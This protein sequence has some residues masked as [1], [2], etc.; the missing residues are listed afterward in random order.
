MIMK[1]LKKTGKIISVMLALLLI[2]QSGFGM[3]IFADDADDPEYA[4]ECELSPAVTDF[5]EITEDNAEPE[6]LLM[7]VDKGTKDREISSIADEAGAAVETVSRMEDG[8]KL[9]AVQI[10]PEAVQETADSLAE[11]ESVLIVQPNYRYSI[12][13]EEI[14]ETT[15]DESSVQGASIQAGETSDI[16]LDRQQYLSDPEG[17][18]YDDSEETDENLSGCINAFGAWSRLGAYSREDRVRVAV[19][20]TGALISHPDLAANINKD[21]CVTFNNGVKGSFKEWDGYEDDHGHGTHVCGIIAAETDNSK[22]VA[23][24]ACNR[25][26]VFCIDAACT[27]NN[28]VFT[29]QDICMS[30][31][32]AVEQGA[33]LINLSIG[34]L[35]RDLLMERSVR[36]AWDRGI[37]CIC[38]A[39]NEGSDAAQSP[40]DSPC[41]ISVKAHDVYGNGVSSSNYS[42][43][44]DV[45]APGKGIF[46]TCLKTTKDSRGRTVPYTPLTATY[47]NKSGTSMAA[48]V[49]TGIAALLLSEDGSLTPRQLKNYIYTSSGQGSYMGLHG[50]PGFGMV[51]AA[52]AVRDLHSSDSSVTDMILNRTYAEIYK[53][54][55]VF[56]E[57]AVLPAEAGRRA[58]DA[59]YSSSDES[60]ASVDS[61]GMITGTGKGTAVISVS[62]GGVSRECIVTVGSAAVKSFSKRPFAVTGYIEEDDPSVIVK[63]SSWDEWASGADIYQT[64]AKAKEKLSVSLTMY[65]SASI[66]YLQITKKD[67]TVLKGKVYA[68]SSSTKKVSFSY[69]V[70]AAGAYRIMVLNKPYNN[71][72]NQSLRYDLKVNSVIMDLS[73]VAVTKKSG[74][75]KSFTVKWKKLSR[76]K[77]KKI[78]KIQLQYSTSFGF[79]SGT[80][81]T[82]YAK[83]NS[84]SK[85]I[86]RLKAGKYYYVRIRGYKKISGVKHYSAWSKTVKVKTR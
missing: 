46:S 26:E 44:K 82:V 10:D 59:V 62:C 45:S 33:Q 17:T 21:L 71:T 19:I 1:R 29:T 67:G 4:A 15:A 49:V 9:A 63:E 50:E 72:G 57:Y 64:N 80:V 68:G 20:D 5:S 65:S 61:Y 34:G 84:S 22:G 78:S 14:Q 23:G 36:N 31:D 79:A 55:S 60:V 69:S 81:K 47:E 18:V 7:L 76:A 51:N 83:N 8:T 66:P 74:G 38:A 86:S 75:K 3:Q 58:G 28:T 42:P 30:I 6:K 56:L 52:S 70:P 25:A 27:D 16:Y 53:G 77:Q 48:P 24:V 40:G 32:Y 39:G 11:S 41:A 13:D 43:D 2:L 73:A 12:E 37:L 35:Y 85:T 54:E